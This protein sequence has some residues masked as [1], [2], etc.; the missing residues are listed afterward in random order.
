LAGALLEQGIA[1]LL[2]DGGALQ[3]GEVRVD[4]VEDDALA[5]GF[6]WG[7]GGPLDAELVKRVGACTHAALIEIGG[8][9]DNDVPALAKLGVALRDL[10]GVAI[11]M[12]AS[13]AA[14][15][16]GPW[17]ADFESG[18]LARI[19]ARTVL[20]VG[21]DGMMFTCGMHQFDLPDA[22]IA[23]GDASEA[24]LWLDAL[25]E[26]QL[27]ERPALLSGHTFRPDSDAERRVLERWPD[28]H[29]HP[30]DGRHNPFGQ[31]RIQTPEVATV[32]AGGLALMIIP[33]LAAQLTFAERSKGS[34]LSQADVETLTSNA[35]AIAM[36]PQ[37]AL[38]ME[39][40]RGY[41]DIEPELAW[42]QWQL[43]RDTM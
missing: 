13:G 12:E 9:L 2:P 23:I 4:V 28:S 41:A 3:A 25:C 15:S 16:W 22:Q 42:E 37:Q 39:R 35:S 24:A 10:G 11:R 21:D 43:V 8:C 6:C 27:E 19:Y 32:T 20:L 29:H 14:C 33:S 38:A 30:D 1:V 17:L 40:S 36:E 5:D 34:P 31:W 7:R 18:E 26:Y